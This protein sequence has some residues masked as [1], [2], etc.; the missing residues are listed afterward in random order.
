[1]LTRAQLRMGRAAIGLSS[2]ELSKISGVSANTINRYE[3]GADALSSTL[4]TLRRCLE[5]EGVAFIEENGGGA[6]VRLK[7]REQL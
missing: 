6:G 2:R 3:N 5:K 7:N 1:M 4:E